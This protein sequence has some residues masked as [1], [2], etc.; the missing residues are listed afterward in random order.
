MKLA[1]S[2][3]NSC[4]RNSSLLSRKEKLNVIGKV[5][6]S[7]VRFKLADVDGKTHSLEQYAGHWLLLVFHR[8]LA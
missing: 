4:P 7:A 5:D 2:P 6:S 3:R 1:Y 8:H